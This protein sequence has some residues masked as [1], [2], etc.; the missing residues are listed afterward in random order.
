MD[1]VK[2]G[3][4]V[5]YTRR[6]GETGAPTIV[7]VNGLA[8]DLRQWDRFAR[9][10]SDRFHIIRFDLRGQGLSSGGDAPFTLTALADDLAGLLDQLD[11]GP[12][13]VIGVEFGALVG[14]HFAMRRP[15]LARALVLM[16]LGSPL[17]SPARWRER[18]VAVEHGG[19]AAIADELLELWLPPPFRAQRPD[20]TRMWRHMLLAAPRSGVVAGCD[21]LADADVAAAA[22]AVHAPSLVLVGAALADARRAAAARLAEL[23]AGTTSTVSGA[24]ML[25]HVAQPAPAAAAILGF[26]EAKGLG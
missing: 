14:L 1:F 2:I 15:E 20:E 18:R 6:D 23:L 16:G 24:A 10:L 26:L 5:L 12:A 13:V 25:V 7:F 17:D 19:V 8:S 22:G 3:D 21:L 11:T 9:Y 4:Q